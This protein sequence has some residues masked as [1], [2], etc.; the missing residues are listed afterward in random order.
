VS[1]ENDWLEERVM[2]LCCVEAFNN[3]M[4]P[5]PKKISERSGQSG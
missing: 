5:F 1:A 4:K 2:I 3:G